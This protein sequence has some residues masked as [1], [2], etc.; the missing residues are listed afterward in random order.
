MAFVTW[1]FGSGG[2]RVAVASHDRSAESS[3]TGDIPV[4]EM[5]LSFTRFQDGQPTTSN[6]AMTNFGDGSIA[7]DLAP[8]GVRVIVGFAGDGFLD[9]SW[10]VANNNITG[11]GHGKGLGKNTYG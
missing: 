10:L 11:K 1:Q 6:V 5:T 7:F 8:V 9:A 2:F 3:L 4:S